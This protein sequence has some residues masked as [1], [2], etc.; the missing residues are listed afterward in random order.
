MGPLGRLS[1]TLRMIL[2]ENGVEQVDDSLANSLVSDILRTIRKYI[3]CVIISLSGSYKGRV[4]RPSIN[5]VR[6]SLPCEVYC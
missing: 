3:L 5:A 1:V 6:N 2:S 4:K